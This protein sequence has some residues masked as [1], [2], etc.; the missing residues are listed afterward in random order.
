MQDTITSKRLTLS[1]LTLA[2]SRFIYELVNTPD[3]IR[4][5]GD[6]NVKTN[7]DAH[8]ISQSSYTAPMIR[9]HD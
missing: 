6:R 8:D 1:K 9:G 2:D 7:E 4:F 3:W 5:I